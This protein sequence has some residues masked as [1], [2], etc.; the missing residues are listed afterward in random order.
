MV[1]SFFGTRDMS[2]HH[3]DEQERATLLDRWVS[4]IA[5]KALIEQ[6]VGH[7]VFKVLQG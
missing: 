4:V 3:D 7:V 1:G 6:L 2:F 5:L